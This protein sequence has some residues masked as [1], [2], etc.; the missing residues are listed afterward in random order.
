VSEFEVTFISHNRKA[1]CPPDPAFPEGMVI[2][3]NTRPACMVNLPYPA[4]C[5]GVWLI[6][7]KSCGYRAAATAAGRPDDV[8]QMR[9]PCK[10]T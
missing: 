9:V 6:V 4:E 3:C 10:L 7:C 1:Q 2:D 5:C 8:R